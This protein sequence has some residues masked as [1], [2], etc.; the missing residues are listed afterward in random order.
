MIPYL[1]LPSRG[2]GRRVLESVERLRIA[3]PVAIFLFVVVQQAWETAVVDT[4]PAALRFAEGVLLYGL[5]GPLVTFWTLDWIARAMAAGEAVEARARRGER[6]LASI[7]SLSADAIFSLDTDE[8]IQSWNQGA[9]E[10]LGYTSGEVTGQHVSV[11]LPSDKRERG[12]LA[13]L[14]DRLLAAGSVRA[15]QTERLRRDGTAVPVELTQTLLK[16]EDGRFMG[17]SVILRDITERVASEAAIRQLNRELEGRVAAR[18]AELAAVTAELRAANAGLVAAN[19]E[20]TQVDALKDEFVSLVSHELRAPLTNINASVELLL[21]GHPPDKIQTK[22][23]IIG[24]EAQR[25][26]RLVRSVLDVSRI[27]AG[28]LELL[29]APADP[30]LLCRSAVARQPADHI[31]QLTLA[32]DTPAVMA[33]VDR[34]PEVLTNLLD[35]AVKYSSPGTAVDISVRPFGADAVL[36]SVADQGVGIPAEELERI[37][38]RFH[39]VERGDARATYGHGLG[40][41]IARRLVEAHGGRMWA[42]STPGV[43]ATF[44]FTLPRAPEEP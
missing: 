33:D 3:L 37:F 12:E 4:W 17:S 43:G 18:T 38:E 27:Q 8:V 22:L 2:T 11:L 32:P 10:I 25:L 29:T 44:L 21:A 39:R 42:E 24:Q 9:E 40:L 23:E 5:V 1:S 7:T 35:N 34:I 16:G 26:T 20:L 36:F 41:Y 15:F 14:R 6:Y 28:R 13:V 30:G 19:I 31:W